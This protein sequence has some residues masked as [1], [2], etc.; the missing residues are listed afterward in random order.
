MNRMSALTNYVQRKPHFQFSIFNFQFKVFALLSF[1]FCLTG[2][3]NEKADRYFQT[4]H[5]DKAI[6]AYR[7]AERNLN[8]EE[9]RNLAQS[10]HKRHRYAEAESVYS[11]FITTTNAE[12][13]DFF[14]YFL[15][16]RAN[17]KYRES[18]VFME[19][20]RQ[21]N[22]NDLRVRNFAETESFLSQW[23]RPNRDFRITLLDFNNKEDDFGA[24]FYGSNQVVFASS[25]RVVPFFRR[26]YNWSQRPFL[27]LYIAD[28]DALNWRNLRYFNRN[29][30]LKWH[31]ASASFSA[32][33]TLMAFTR[34]NYSGTEADDVVRLQ[35]YFLEKDTNGKWGEPVAFPL[36]N[37][38][39][40]VGQPALVEG[41]MY[42]ASD[43]PDGFGGTDIYFIEKNENGTWGEPVNLGTN[44]NT[45]GNEMFPFFDKRTQTLYFS[46]NGL[47]GLGGL[48]VFSAQKTAQGFEP[49][50]NLGA[51]V[52]SR[53]D[54]FAYVVHQ[55]GT[56]GY[57]SSNRPTGKGGDDIY[58]FSYSG[59]IETSTP[60]ETG[61]TPSLPDELN[62][63]FRLF[64][65]NENT[66][67]P[68]N[69]ATVK[70]GD[71]AMETTDRHGMVSLLLSDTITFRAT[72]TA[73]G[74][75]TAEKLIQ[76]SKFRH[77]DII[78]DTLYLAPAVGQQIVL[79]NI[80]YDFDKADILPESAEELDKLVNFLL[81]NP[82]L[83]V[84]LSSHTDS[85]GSDAYNLHLSKLR[86]QSAVNYILS[87]GIS[88]DRIS[89]RG[90]GE[91]RLRNRCANAVICSEEEHRENRRTEIFITEFG[92]AQHISTPQQC[93]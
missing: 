81:D 1:V 29:I 47:N 33:E 3:A 89:A 34:N 59:E 17:G 88:S 63:I 52:N 71:F 78:V 10:L 18:A 8:V 60:V 84:E 79:R 39:Y 41:G 65:L 72:A 22:P 92:A 35:I 36:N 20:L 13:E 90:Y 58:H 91:T 53:S 11:R 23:Q 86:A 93:L 57:F 2:S 27:K 51:P 70:F 30:N 87:K 21:A 32:D 68:I 28:V 46:S 26:I 31:E 6:E 12:T 14:N 49:A 55:S 48:D 69:K 38:A 50:Q 54:D 24:V 7:S 9:L 66:R 45:E 80:Y 73:I 77:R 83:K 19:K 15:L 42:F 62:Y 82:T 4:Y 40:S 61:R 56:F 16:L 85:R 75:C 37:P 25:R 76:I 43:M 5:F 67:Q 74:Y 64:V 44:I